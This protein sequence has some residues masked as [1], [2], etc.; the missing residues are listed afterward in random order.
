MMEGQHDEYS[1]G[2]ANVTNW[3]ADG[4][5]KFECEYS[6]GVNKIT[7]I[8]KS[9]NENMF[10][11][12][13]V[14]PNKKYRLTVDYKTNCTSWSE[15]YYHHTSDYASLSLNC[16]YIANIPQGDGD[17]PKGVMARTD[18]FEASDEYHTYTC[19]FESGD[20]ST[21]YIS[22]NLAAVHDGVEY[23]HWYKDV[24]IQEI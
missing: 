19:E 22:F 1:K 15:L 21:L 2:F 13:N 4:F 5:Q 10:C 7:I 16:A 6:S 11:P 3:T 18:F 9:G 23:I 12:V 14:K 20:Y 8:C 24:R 17:Y